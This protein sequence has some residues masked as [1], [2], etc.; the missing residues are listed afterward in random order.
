MEST[1][2]FFIQSAQ[3]SI[4]DT[5]KQYKESADVTLRPISV[6]F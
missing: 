4:Y 5:K 6:V 3:F 1:N 2:P